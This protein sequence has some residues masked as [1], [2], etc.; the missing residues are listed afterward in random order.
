MLCSGLRVVL[1]VVPEAVLVVEIGGNQK[2]FRAE[3]LMQDML[4]V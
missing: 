1:L 3:Q 2:I 4:L